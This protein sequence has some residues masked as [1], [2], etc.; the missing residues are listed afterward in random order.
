[1]LFPALFCA[2]LRNEYDVRVYNSTPNTLNSVKINGNSVGN[3]SSFR[4]SEKVTTKTK[5][6][7]LRYEVVYCLIGCTYTQKSCSTTISED[8]ETL[9]TIDIYNLGNDCKEK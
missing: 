8:T 7:T 3:L 4:N 5:E 9:H 2:N 1:M 6:I